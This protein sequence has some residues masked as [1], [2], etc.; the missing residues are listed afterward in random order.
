[1]INLNKELQPEYLQHLP[2]GWC[3]S[4]VK[5]A[6]VKCVCFSETECVLGI[7]EGPYMMLHNTERRYGGRVTYLSGENER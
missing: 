4:E 1:M 2:S 7:P 5:R 6:R 3:V